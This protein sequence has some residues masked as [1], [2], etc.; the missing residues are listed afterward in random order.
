MRSAHLYFACIVL[1]S[2]SSSCKNQPASNDQQVDQ[3]AMLT[4]E[5]PGFSLQ[6]PI[7]NETQR[8]QDYGVGKLKV[9]ASAGTWISDVTWQPSASIATLDVIAAAF[10]AG[11]SPNASYQIVRHEGHATAEIHHNDIGVR[12][13]IL[14]CGKRAIIIRTTFYDAAGGALHNHA[15]RTFKC[16][17]LPAQEDLPNAVPIWLPL[18]SFKLHDQSSV[19]MLSN[20]E[21]QI[22]IVTRPAIRKE[23]EPAA[24]RVV[25]T[26]IE[27]GADAIVGNPTPAG[28]FAFSKNGEQIGGVRFVTCTTTTTTIFGTSASQAGYLQ[29]MAAIAQARCLRDGEQPVAWQRQN[30]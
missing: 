18:P 10:T 26:S 20:D 17:A 7:G 22:V 6:L 16:K 2:F 9:T 28:I 24:A 3:Q 19:T 14:P 11:L 13:T 4:Y 15:L 21:A 5:L 30:K 23:D 29:L 1:S 8:G 25:V 12:Q 27:G